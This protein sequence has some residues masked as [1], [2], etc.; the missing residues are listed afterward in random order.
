[1]LSIEPK[2]KKKKISESNICTFATKQ[3][4]EWFVSNTDLL[5]F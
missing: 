2:V 4:T 1:M 3:L 5:I